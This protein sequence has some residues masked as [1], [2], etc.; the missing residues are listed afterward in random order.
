MKIAIDSSQIL[1]ETG[2]SRYTKNLI[3]GLLQIDKENQYIIF[4]GSLRRYIELKNRLKGFK[5]KNNHNIFTKVFP[6]P[7]KFMDFIWNRLHT[8]PIERLVGDIEVLHSSD[9]AQPPTKA[10]KITTV[11]DVIPIKYPKLSH[12]TIVSTHE[13]RFNI[14]KRDVDAIIC[15]S[16]ATK[17]D[18]INLGV[19][20]HKIFVIPEA[21]EPIFKA[22]KKNQIQKIKTKFRIEGDYLISVGITPRK[23]VERIIQAYEQVRVGKK[24][25]L[26]VVGEAKT[27]IPY[28]RG[29]IFTG[30]VQS[31][32][33][34][35][36][37]SGAEVL[38][39]PSLYEGFGLPI[40]EAFSCKVPVVTSS[41]GSMRE[42]AGTS[43]V[44]VDPYSVVSIAEGIRKAI[45]TRSLLVKKGSERV[46]IFN[47][48]DIARSTLQLYQK[49]QEEKYKT[50]EIKKERA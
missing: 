10:Y 36:L 43:A 27:D 7:P 28:R 3:E 38:V 46:K 6:L 20:L 15:P 26:V 14:V 39:Y 16:E 17:T 8:L 33:L 40:L 12:P 34:A 42:A 29:V 9:W 2:V 25:K 4:G 19:P 44:L 32:E 30:H 41:F 47:W 35:I 22:A 24:L 49:S 50:I 48:T 21:P 18:L 11:H 5:L 23:N 1:Y 31:N 13:R 37:Y 45:D